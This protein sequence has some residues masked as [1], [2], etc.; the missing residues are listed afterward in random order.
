MKRKVSNIR[1]AIRFR[2]L[3]S[4]VKT[5]NI[6][7]DNNEIILSRDKKGR[8]TQIEKTFKFDHIFGSEYKTKQIYDELV[9]QNIKY[10][11]DGY[12]STIFAY[13]QT[14]SG[15]TYTMIGT[16]EETGIIPLAINQLFNEIE[17]S[18]SRTYL[19]SFNYF[20]IY[21]EKIY[22]LIE[23]YYNKIS[24]ERVPV[25]SAKHL[26][27]RIVTTNNE[28][29]ELINDISKERSVSSN[30]INEYSSRSHCI[31]RIIVESKDVTEL[32]NSYISYLDLVDLAGSECQGQ[33]G[34]MGQAQNEA[35]SINKSLLAL[36]KVVRSI[37]EQC[38]SSRDENEDNNT[39]NFR[40][41]FINYRESV[42]THQLENSLGG[43]C[44]TVFIITVSNEL[45]NMQSSINSLR[46]GES[47]KLIK[48]TPKVNEIKDKKSLLIQE[49]IE[50]IRKLQKENETLRQQFSNEARIQ[51]NLTQIFEKEKFLLGGN[52]EATKALI[53]N[54]SININISS[55]DERDYKNIQNSKR[56]KKKN[57][58]KSLLNLDGIPFSLEVTESQFTSN[59]FVD[60]LPLINYLENKNNDIHSNDNSLYIRDIN[61]DDLPTKVS[62]KTFQNKSEQKRRDLEIAIQELTSSTILADNINQLQ[63][64]QMRIEILENENMHL[65]NKIAAINERV[66]KENDQKSKDFDD[67]IKQITD[68]LNKERENLNSVICAN[69]EYKFKIQQYEEI[70]AKYYQLSQTYEEERNNYENEIDR[71]VYLIEER[72]QYFRNEKNSISIKLEQKEFEYNT[73]IE[74]MEKNIKDR[75]SKILDL[76]EK[77][78]K[79]EQ[80]IQQ[81]EEENDCIYENLKK[82][83][84]DKETEIERLVSIVYTNSPSPNTNTVRHPSLN[85]QLKEKIALIKSRAN[86]NLVTE[87]IFD[88][89]THI[90]PNAESREGKD[91]ITS[92]L[93]IFITVFFMLIFRFVIT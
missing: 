50:I 52:I 56:S 40:K 23:I 46:F 92:L 31:L 26:K 75:D 81:K 58:I 89:D 28:M 1:V 16:K 90:K 51:E 63:E 10:L 41:G 93:V 79:M 91:R 68:A 45:S 62:R 3:N 2:P 78:E 42:L 49:Y 69:E 13:G 86:K 55:E 47:A 27:K 39:N 30:N 19:I 35:A 88:L 38:E 67:R 5:F 61:V 8:V 21:M 48:N 17:H 76:C 33:T 60:D 32:N 34:A 71:L 70:V 82:Q 54:S 4:D 14:G 20:E 36:G 74:K 11:I 65:K 22:D 44:N 87:T 53:S 7:Y 12:N 6:D 24:K 25:V 59:E 73:N 84:T 18:Y 80:Y 9:C 29:I 43:N 64:Y 15:K 72:E 83:L 37:S 85:M 77:I 66:A 57:D